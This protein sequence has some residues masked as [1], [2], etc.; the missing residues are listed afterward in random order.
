VVDR[1]G[2]MGTAIVPKGFDPLPSRPRAYPPDVAPFPP[3]P[4]VAAAPAVVRAGRSVVV[5]AE[6]VEVVAARG[7]DALMALDALTP[8]WWAGVLTYDLGRAVER[9]TT[10]LPDAPHLPDV[11]L[12]RYGAR[13]ELDDEGGRMVGGRAARARLQGLLDRTPTPAPP[14]SLGPPRSTLERD[15]F[16]AGVRAIVALIEAGECYQV[17]LTRRLWWERAANPNALFR[18]LAMRNPAPHAALLALPRPA[19]DPLRVV[20]ASPERFL[21]WHH[22]DVQTRPIKGTAREADDLRGSTKDR[23][24]NV[25]IVDLARNDLGRVCEYGSVH[26]PALCAIEAHPG[27]H[28]FVSTVRGTLRADAGIGSLVRATFPPASVTGA[29][30]PRVLQAIEDLEPVRRGVYCGAVGWIDTEHGAGD[31]AVAIR[32]FAIADGVTQ[33]GVGAGIVAD[34]DPTTEWHETE[35]KA[36]RLLMAAGPSERS[37]VG[38]PS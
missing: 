18:A 5:A 13:L 1:L 9:V 16:E 21:A 20:S 27:L 33:L 23:A 3:V 10:R 12:A 31:L 8:G 15:E 36:A 19:G 34:S 24:E 11:L 30:K 14:T 2:I 4:D 17:N 29:P 38:A 28:H 22:R 32:T 7:G 6:P 35:L 26:V 25:I 37:T